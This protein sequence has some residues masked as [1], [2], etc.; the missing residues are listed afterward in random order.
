MKEKY[1]RFNKDSKEEASAYLK[2]LFKFPEPNPER[3]H[4]KGNVLCNT[5]QSC[6]FELETEKVKTE[7]DQ[8][9]IEVEVTSDE[10]KKE[11]TKTANLRANLKR[12]TE[13]EN[14]YREKC[15]K[16]RENDSNNSHDIETIVNLECKIREMNKEL[17]ELRSENK[18]M[19]EKIGEVDNDI[20]QTFNHEKRCFNTAVTRCVYD[21]LDNHVAI[22]KVTSCITSVISNLTGKTCER[23]PSK[24]TVENMNI[25]RVCVAQQQL[26]TELP[27]KSDT[28]LYSDET[29]KYGEK[30]MG[31]HLSDNDKRYYTL[32]LRDIATKSANDTL[33]TFKELLH[34]LDDVQEET[35]A[36]KKILTNIK[37]TMSDRAATE[38]KWHEL[39]NVH[40]KEVLP[41]MVEN[42]D[43][44]TDDAKAPLENI[45]SFFCGLHSLI[46]Y[47]E[48]S[49]QALSSI[50]EQYSDGKGCGAATKGLAF[51][52]ESTNSTVRL[53]KTASKAFARGG[54]EQAGVHGQ[55][56]VYC[57]GF[58]EE[59]KMKSLP[60]VPFRGN[61]FN[62]LFFNAA[63]VY[64]LHHKMLAFLTSTGATNKLLKSVE[65][66]LQEPFILAGC[67]ALGLVSKLVTSPLWRHI[68]DKT[69]H[70]LDL[71]EVFQRT[72]DLLKEGSSSA[73]KFINGDLQDIADD[74]HVEDPVFQC[75]TEPCDN[76]GLTVT[77]LGTLLPALSKVMKSHSTYLN[78]LQDTSRESTLSV[79]KHNKHAER[80]FAYLDH[81][82]KVRPNAT[83]L[84][85]EATI[86]FS[87]NRTSEWLHQLPSNEVEKIISDAR[88]KARIV[89]KKFQ[90]RTAVIVAQKQEALKRKEHEKQEKELKKLRD[91]EKYTCDIHYYGLWQSAREV[92]ETLNSMESVTGKV[93]ALKAQLRFRQQVLRQIHPNQEI[94]AFSSKGSAHPWQHLAENVKEL[95]QH[96]FTLQPTSQQS[97]DKP[98][99]VGKRVR[100]N[101]KH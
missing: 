18:A 50:E 72:T 5:H 90:E 47:A 76:D 67:R 6:Q 99:L 40:R 63:F 78:D 56:K 93:T 59:H 14:Y 55:F 10:L 66:D 12:T 58:L 87:L 31:Y 16:V 35:D 54:S 36:G 41:S 62:I 4:P 89:Q 65:A 43:S 26:A 29:S 64:F 73:D 83:L 94:Y 15:K 48:V 60:L 91:L 24:S 23:L 81:L 39:L 68:E 80:V 86:M 3:C 9:K 96:S 7:L 32:G 28:T 46:Q 38:L 27:T 20:I 11:K 70:I 101:I 44:L 79:D 61:R 98:L 37:N 17:I 97:D 34:D 8:K 82:M 77:I 30:V 85:N 45:T 95:I 69:Q 13:R 74:V 75:L 49:E 53:I 52:N 42:W 84:A 1:Q 33:S 92:D 71:P 57:K 19:K 22:T 25:Q 21:L 2:E 100:V 51:K 88:K